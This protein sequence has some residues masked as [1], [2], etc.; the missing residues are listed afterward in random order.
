VLYGN[1]YKTSSF[2]DGRI[3]A[4]GGDRAIVPIF[5]ACR[6]GKKGFPLYPL[7]VKTAGLLGETRIFIAV[8]IP[9]AYSIE[10]TG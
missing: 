2:G 9:A 7:R 8:R 4:C 1:D 6:A 3:P 5:F 10:K